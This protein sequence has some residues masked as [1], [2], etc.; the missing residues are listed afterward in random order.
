MSPGGTCQ[1]GDPRAWNKQRQ[2]RNLRPGIAGHLPQ[3]LETLSTADHQPVQAFRFDPPWQLVWRVGW[4]V[5]AIQLQI[6]DTSTKRAQ[7]LGEQFTTALS[8]Q[9][10]HLRAGLVER[11]AQT[12]QLQQGFTVI[13][14]S[15]EADIETMLA[16]NACGRRADAEPRH[17]QWRR[18]FGLEQIHRNP[19]RRFADHNDRAASGQSRNRLANSVR[20]RQRNNVQKRQATAE[21]PVPGQLFGQRR[22]VVC[23]ARQQQAPG[24]HS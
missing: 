18:A 20:E 2:L 17:A 10:H 3:V 14:V 6:L 19:R 15:R 23:R 7:A 11:L 22:A 13:A 1:L 24:C 8:A 21:N 12:R 4:Q 5:A 9:D 16:K